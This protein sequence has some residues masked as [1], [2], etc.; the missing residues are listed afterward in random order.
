MGTEIEVF[1]ESRFPALMGAAGELAEIIAENLGP[2]GLQPQDLTRISIPTGG[3][4][5][6]QVETLTGIEDYKSIEG[7]V[8]AWGTTRKYW[9]LG[10][11]DAAETTPP[12]CASAD[13][14]I[15]SGQFGAGSSLHPSGDCITC[16]MNQWG[17][18][19]DEPGDKGPK[20]CAEGKLLFILR[21][22]DIIPV[23]ITCPPTSIKPLRTYMT[24]L[25]KAQKAAS[26]VVT[27]LELERAESAGRKWSVVR[28]TLTGI[29]EPAAA[30]Q[31]KA[32]GASV[33]GDYLARMAE[34][35]SSAAA[36][37]VIDVDD[38]TATTASD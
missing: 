4:T 29:L 7:V 9:A 26:G 19:S 14:S 38:V 32:M 31:A 2:D 1:E 24:E 11:D 35:R 28:P 36:G 12:D 33:K 15:G 23:T 5:S 37:D 18:G 3:A 16:P 30:A 20:A 34:L 22:G 10:L 8:I 21:E 17:S 27:K 13:G 25:V 6:W